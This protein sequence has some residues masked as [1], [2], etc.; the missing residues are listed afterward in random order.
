M[1]IRL[2]TC[3]LILTAIP[4]NLAFAQTDPPNEID[5]Q[6]PT[7]DMPTVANIE[8]LDLIGGEDN[9]DVTGFNFFEINDPNAHL[10][11]ATG[12]IAETVGDPTTTAGLWWDIDLKVSVPV[13]ELDPST[14]RPRE[15]VMLGI[16][17]DVLNETRW[18]WTDF[19]MTIGMRDPV[20]GEF[21]ESDEFD[22]LFFKTDPAPRTHDGLF[23]DPPEMD[24]PVAP[25][26][27]DWFA[28]NSP[29]VLPGQTAFFWLGIQIPPHKFDPQTGMAR[30]VLREHATIPEPATIALLAC[31]GLALVSLRR[32]TV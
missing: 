27:L 1:N 23:D 19:H 20:T 18:R 21:M 4:A 31:S 26:N 25:D 5:S 8:F 29:G 32:W 3:L 17:K 24:E 10:G 30:I 13:G 2:L 9:V 7:G 22:F 6:P 12:S 15:P 14:G 16:D 28:R 11:L